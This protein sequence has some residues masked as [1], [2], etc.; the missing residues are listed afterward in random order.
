MYGGA[1]FVSS[2]INYHLIDE[3]NLFLNPTAIGDGLKIFSERIPFTLT[4]S[5]AYAC[6]IVVN[7]Y[8]SANK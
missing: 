6:G 1:I 4:G 5:K 8:K 7:K 2:L 3:L